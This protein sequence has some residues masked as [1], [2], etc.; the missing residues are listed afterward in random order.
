MRWDPSKSPDTF[1]VANQVTTDTQE[2][3]GVEDEAE[4]RCEPFLGET[5]HGQSFVRVYEVDGNLRRS[6]PSMSVQRGMRRLS[7]T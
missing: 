1:V 7:S 5:I 6:T 2:D 3:A 4:E